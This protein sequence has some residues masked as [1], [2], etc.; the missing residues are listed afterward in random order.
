[1]Q[2]KFSAISAKPNWNGAP[3]PDVRGDVRS[4]DSGK[5]IDHQ[6]VTGKKL[7]VD[8]VSGTGFRALNHFNGGLIN[9]NNGT[10]PTELD[11]RKLAAVPIQR[12]VVIGH[13]RVVSSQG[14]SRFQQQFNWPA[15]VGAEFLGLSINQQQ[16]GLS[17]SVV[18]GG[19]A[20]RNEH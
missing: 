18:K 6:A 16:Y 7:V 20:C 13:E 5:T 12:R 11:H 15:R 17:C 9:N 8:Q 3:E 1:M 14:K 19:Q 10:S 4:R 2:Q